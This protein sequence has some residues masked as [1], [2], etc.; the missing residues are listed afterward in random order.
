MPQRY[1]TEGYRSTFLCE[2]TGFPA[3]QYKWLTP[4][5]KQIRSFSDVYVDGGNL[6]FI[7][8]DKTMLKGKY[9]CVAYIEIAETKQQIGQ[10][11]AVVDV[12]DVFGKGH[13]LSKF[14]NFECDIM[15][16]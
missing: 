12:V 7:S 15:F 2:A 10:A 5:G 6:T 16:Y 11:S 13:S 1:L 8:V 14:L 9:T 3:P 4:D